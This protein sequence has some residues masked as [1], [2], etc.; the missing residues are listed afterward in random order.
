[1]INTQSLLKE[2]KSYVDQINQD[3]MNKI[4]FTKTECQVPSHAPIPGC[5][6][7]GVAPDFRGS[8]EAAAGSPGS[9][10]A[11]AVFPG[12]EEAAA[13][14][15]RSEEVAAGSP[16]SEGAGAGFPVVGCC[17]RMDS[18]VAADPGQGRGRHSR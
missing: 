9:E 2:Y 7:L 3:Y 8:E 10:E 4:G 12:S 14:F 16:W 1:M 11:A 18:V 5:L 13:D 6:A 17:Q 15:P